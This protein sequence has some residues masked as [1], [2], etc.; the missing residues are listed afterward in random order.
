MAPRH[1]NKEIQAVIEEAVNLGW[2]LVYKGSP[3]YGELL[4]P[5]NDTTCR[6]GDYCRRSVNCTPRSPQNHAKDLIKGVRKC[7]KLNP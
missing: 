7:T 1:Q 6:S 4:C 2:R 5:F 3:I